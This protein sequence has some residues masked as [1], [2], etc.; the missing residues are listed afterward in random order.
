VNAYAEDISIWPDELRCSYFGKKAQV[1]KEGE[2]KG[3]MKEHTKRLIDE[4]TCQGSWHPLWL[5]GQLPLMLNEVDR[6]KA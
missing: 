6:A 3:C 5:T 1:I 2:H 4:E